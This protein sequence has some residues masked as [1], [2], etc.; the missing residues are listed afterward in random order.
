MNPTA[1]LKSDP[2]R[3]AGVCVLGVAWEKTDGFEVPIRRGRICGRAE[4]AR[5]PRLKIKWTW[6]PVESLSNE[7][8]ARFRRQRWQSCVSC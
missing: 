8:K 2:A 4:M 6:I 1:D 7:I 3:G 5:E